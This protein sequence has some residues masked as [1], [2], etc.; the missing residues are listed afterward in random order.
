MEQGNLSN[1]GTQDS[2]EKYKARFRKNKDSIQ[3]DATEPRTIPNDLKLQN[4]EEAL[5]DIYSSR[6][7]SKVLQREMYIPPMTV[8]AMPTKQMLPIFTKQFLH[9]YL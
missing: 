6:P 7:F 8:V 2:P 9:R 4:I 3:L 1:S 5:E